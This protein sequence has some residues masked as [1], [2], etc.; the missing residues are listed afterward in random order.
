MQN[1]PKDIPYGGLDANKIRTA[2]P[3]VNSEMLKQFRY[4]VTNR[5]KIHLKKDVEKQAFPWTDDLILSQYRFTNVRREQDR[6]TLYLINMMKEHGN[7]F[8]YN[9]VCNILLF[10]LFNKIE[11]SELIGGWV[12]FENY[13]EDRIKTQLKNVT[14]SYVYYTNAYYTSGMIANIRKHYPDKTFSVINIPNVVRDYGK[15]LTELLRQSNTPQQVIQALKVVPGVGEFL[16]YQL[17]IDLTY[18]DDF[19]WSEN[20]FV[21]CG[22]GCKRGLNYLF[23]DKAELTNEELLFWVRDNQIISDAMCRD[24]MLDLPINERHMNVMSL[25]NCFCEF[26]KYIKAKSGK[27]RPRNNYTPGGGYEKTV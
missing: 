26:Q 21:M 23:D 20:E 24:L 17:F 27:G 3:V 4:Y 2:K 16:S 11:T 10:R 14:K 5:Y 1:K 6:N 7:K 9:M 19:P 18:L 8:G 13:N 12:D 25:E 22:P 15:R